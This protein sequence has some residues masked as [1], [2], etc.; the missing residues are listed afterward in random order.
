M[1]LRVN[2]RRTRRLLPGALTVAK[3]E[4]KWKRTCPVLTRYARMPLSA[5]GWRRKLALRR[6]NPF[7]SKWPKGGLRSPSAPRRRRIDSL[8]ESRPAQLGLRHCARLTKG[9]SE[10]LYYQVAVVGRMNGALQMESYPKFHNE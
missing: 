6:I 9:F 8:N 10:S 2:R 1:T 4:Q 5:F 3:V 7:S